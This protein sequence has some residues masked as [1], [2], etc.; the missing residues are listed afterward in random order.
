MEGTQIR[1]VVDRLLGDR[2]LDLVR[3]WTGRQDSTPDPCRQAPLAAIVI[4]ASGQVGAPVRVTARAQVTGSF[5][6]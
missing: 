1:L 5:V 4:R 2:H 6:A 3:L